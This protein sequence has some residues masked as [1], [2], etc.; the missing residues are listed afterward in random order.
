MREMKIREIAE[1]V[2]GEVSGDAE[3]EVSSVAELGSAGAGQVAF[4]DQREAQLG[5][6][7]CVLVG[8]SFNGA[9][10][11]TIIR[12]DDPKLA[13]S[14]VATILHPRRS[15]VA[16]RHSSAV[17]SSSATVGKE[18]FLGAFTCVGDGS[19]VGDGTVLR[20]GAKVGDNVRLGDNCVL[21][22]NAFIEDGCTIGKN[23]I[24]HAGVV[25]GAPGFGYVRDPHGEYHQFPQIGTVVIEDNVEI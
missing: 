4:C 3:A 8:R 10:A 13:F 18:V 21:H 2:G 25:I 6:A 16:E 1:L 19:V 11:T 23:V 17:V 9:T 14:E 20:A 15:Y 12:V 22:P 24:L 5:S 7:T